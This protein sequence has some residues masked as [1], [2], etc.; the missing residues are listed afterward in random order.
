M[1]ASQVGDAVCSVDASQENIQVMPR[2]ERTMTRDSD[3]MR[4]FLNS[5]K[6]QCCT[7]LAQRAAKGGA[8]GRIGWH[9]GPRRLAQMAA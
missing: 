5:A 1:V 4:R 6:M 3:P 2:T 8:K 7:G 9:K